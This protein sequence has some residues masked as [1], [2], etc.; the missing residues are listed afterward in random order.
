[1][2]KYVRKWI[3]LK[4]ENNHKI[5]IFS[6]HKIICFRGKVKKINSGYIKWGKYLISKQ[7]IKYELVCVCS[8]AH[9]IHILLSMDCAPPNSTDMEFHSVQD[10]GNFRLQGIVLIQGSNL[11]LLLLWHQQ[12]DSLPLW[13]LGSSCDPNFFWNIIYS[14]Y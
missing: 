1:M 6:W 10:Y 3:L 12:G 7:Y 4:T 8:V 2:E 9:L 5:E 14:S 11:H 13:H